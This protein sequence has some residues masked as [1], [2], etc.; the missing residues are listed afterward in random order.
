M[1]F[2]EGEEH[3]IKRGRRWRKR[4]GEGG[5]NHI[6]TEGRKVR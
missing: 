4:D 3:T 6:E 1:G 5:G 2:S